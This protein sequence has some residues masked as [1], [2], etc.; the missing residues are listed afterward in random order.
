MSKC[1]ICNNTRGNIGYVIKEMMFGT[2]DEFPYFECSR[3]G[4]LQ[5]ET[6]PD[7][8]ERYYASSYYSIADPRSVSQYFKKCW[9]TLSMQNSAVVRWTLDKIFENHKL[10][11]WM[12]HGH[13][14]REDRI[15]DVGCGSGGLLRLM[16]SVGFRN[17]TGIDTGLK[18]ESVQD[19]LK[20]YNSDIFD[21]NESYD[22][23]MFNR[24]FEHIP[25]P[26]KT[27]RK[28]YSLIS[29]GRYVMVRVPVM[30]SYAWRTYR[31]NWI[32]IDAPRHFFL[33]T[34]KSLS[35]LAEQCGFYVDKVRYDSNTS[36]FWG[37]E[38]YRRDIS[39]YNKRHRRRIPFF[40][41]MPVTSYYYYKKNAR[42]L[43]QNNDGDMAAFY[44]R[45][46]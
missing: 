38:M 28:A 37:S 11:D 25:D 46:Q 24:S 22:L 4:T 17:L 6:V 26:V 1:R 2:R 13:F 29:P 35:A 40:H 12:K 20:I 33:Y 42:E 15:L 27:L 31:E 23:I 44:L 43:N 3:C 39:L 41:G 32:Q 45:K 9:L 19:N 34:Q 36:Q 10:V 30:G 14:S 5:I 21:L 7:N 8:V 16:N 18:T